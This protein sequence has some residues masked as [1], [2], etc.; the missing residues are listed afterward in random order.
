MPETPDSSPSRSPRQA[1]GSDLRFS[2]EP[3]CTDT[4]CTRHFFSLVSYNTKF[5]NPK[6]L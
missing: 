2:K 5:R 6:R 4:A 3:G 1:A